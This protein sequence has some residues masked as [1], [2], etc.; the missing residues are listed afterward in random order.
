M[1]IW[2]V[3][4]GAT[5]APA[6]VAIGWTDV[7]LSPGGRDQARELAARLVSVALDV[8]FTSDLARCRD[9]AAAIA[10]HRGIPVVATPDLRELNFGRWEGRRLQELWVEA[11]GEA[12]AWESDIRRLPASFGETFD[13]FEARLRR[14]ADEIPADAEVL[15]V[16]HR[17]SLAVLWS[18]LTGGSLAAAW[19]RSFELGSVTRVEAVAC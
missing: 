18:V 17:G 1:T 8:V 7:G 19:E 13:Q 10:A 11:A 3:R 12:A 4:H 2:L 9:T 16:G 15:V 6:G 5:V 14:F